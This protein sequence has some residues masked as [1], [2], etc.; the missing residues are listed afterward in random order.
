MKNIF[1]H[2]LRIHMKNEYISADNESYLI[3]S[4][5]PDF[6]LGKCFSLTFKTSFQKKGINTIALHAKPKSCMIIVVHRKGA[7]LFFNCVSAFTRSASL[8][9]R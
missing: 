9:A 7:F 6:I 5:F 3:W 1:F 8:R 4:E 2:T